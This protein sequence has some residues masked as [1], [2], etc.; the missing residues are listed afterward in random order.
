MTFRD[1]DSD[2]DSSRD[3]AVVAIRDNDSDSDS[4]NCN[5]NA[6]VAETCDCDCGNVDATMTET[7]CD[8]ERLQ[9]GR[10]PIRAATLHIC[11]GLQSQQSGIVVAQECGGKQNLIYR[12]NAG[13]HHKH[14]LERPRPYTDAGPILLCSVSP[15]KCLVEDLMPRP[16]L[17]LLLH[18]V[19]R[20][21]PQHEQDTEQIASQQTDLDTSESNQI[22]GVNLP[23]VGIPTILTL[24]AH[25]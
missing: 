8:R 9:E 1:Y 25:I 10:L 15:Q 5:R 2:S 14:Q 17:D 21:R 12:G 19:D 22:D 24:G 20:A 6:T 13:V 23:R 18:A 7:I 4:G 16:L 3:I 11:T